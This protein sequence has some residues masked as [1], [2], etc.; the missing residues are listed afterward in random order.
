MMNAQTLIL[1]PSSQTSH[2]NNN[3]NNNNNKNNN[4]YIFK[5]AHL[6]FRESTHN[7]N[8]NCKNGANICIMAGLSSFYMGSCS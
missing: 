2:N 8:K 6:R 7:L 3:N 4:N 5:Y 1:K